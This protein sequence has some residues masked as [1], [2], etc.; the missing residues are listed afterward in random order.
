VNSAIYTGTVRHRRFAP[1]FHAF[2]YR[3]FM[4]YVDLAEIPQ[5]F[6]GR[7]LWSATRPA[8]ARFRRT[9]YLGDPTVPLDEAVRRVVVERTG[10]RPEGPIRLL[11][12]LRYFGYIQNPVSFY[13]C[14]AHDGVTLDAIVAEVTNTPWAERHV[15]VLPAQPA[16]KR[17]H[18]RM[19]KSLHVSPFMAMEQSYAW[20]LTAPASRLTIHMQNHEAGARVFDATMVLARRT[21]TAGSLA[22]VLVSFPMMTA[23]VVTAIYWQAVRLWLKRVPFHVNP[24]RHNVVAPGDAPA[25]TTR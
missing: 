1:V 7:W 11:T 22:A 6:Q 14:F 24:S 19:P 10:A 20:W 25:V 15:Y 9:D 21:A 18:A 12:N 5:L 17:V 13:Y 4:M 8:L 16:A 2:R 23:R 3:V